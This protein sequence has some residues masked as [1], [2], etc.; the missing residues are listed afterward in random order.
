MFSDW[1]TASE[2][3]HRQNAKNDLNVN[4]HFCQIMAA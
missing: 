4:G 1:K 2:D 3:W